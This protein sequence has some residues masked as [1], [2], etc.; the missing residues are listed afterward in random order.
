MPEL[1]LRP[2]TETEFAEWNDASAQEYARIQVAAGVW[3]A[4]QAVAQSLTQRRALLP[5]GVATTGMVLRRAELPDGTPI[6]I[7]WIGLSHP[8]GTPDCAFLYDIEID[9]P[10]RGKGYGRAL[11][12]ACED[13]VAARGIG[14][15]ELNVFGD[16]TA[17]LRL[18]E[19]SGYRVV[20]QQMRKTLGVTP[21]GERD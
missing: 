2:M 12:S 9:E 3:S 18:Y 16:N 11:L 1:T 4:E 8:R 7:T 14:A 20:T 5:D 10:H 21:A 6:G 13:L 19:T 15:L 17:A